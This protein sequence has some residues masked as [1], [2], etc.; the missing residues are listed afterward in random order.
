ME[1]LGIQSIVVS[2]KVT[3]VADAMHAEQIRIVTALSHRPLVS[4][5]N[6]IGWEMKYS[7][8]YKFYS[9]NCRETK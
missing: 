5:S 4:D 2:V 1:G 9:Y 8:L 3:L 7:W 6:E